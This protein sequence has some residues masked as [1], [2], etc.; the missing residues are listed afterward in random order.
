[1]K[2]STS[3]EA[4]TTDWTPTVG[5]LMRGIVEWVQ[6]CMYEALL[7]A[8]YSDL[9]RAQMKVFRFPSPDGLRPSELAN[10]L[11]ITKQAVNDLLGYLEDV[12]YLVRE[13]DPLDRRARIIRLTPSGRQVLYTVRDAAKAAEEQIAKHLGSRRFASMQASLVIAREFVREL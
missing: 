4:N 6:E 13:I 7:D 8:G 10:N 9:T 12:G 11:L 5:A 3:V 1:M 2:M